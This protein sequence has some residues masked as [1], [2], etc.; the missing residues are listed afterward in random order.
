MDFSDFD[1]PDFDPSFFNTLDT[2]VDAAS[3]LPTQGSV[4]SE[5]TLQASARSNVPLHLNKVDGSNKSSNP[6][7]TRREA[8][9][10]ALSVNAP[11]PPRTEIHTTTSTTAPRSRTT[12]ASIAAPRS[13]VGTR[14]T[15]N[16]GA[17]DSRFPQIM[18]SCHARATSS[19]YHTTILD[20]DDSSNEVSTI[21][22]ADVGIR[23]KE[24]VFEG[25]PSRALTTSALPSSSTHISC[26]KSRHSSEATVV[27]ETANTPTYAQSR[28]IQRDPA[29]NSKNGSLVK[30]WD[31]TQY[32]ATG[33]RAQRK[34]AKEKARLAARRSNFFN[35]QDMGESESDDS[36]DD[37]NESTLFPEPVTGTFLLCRSSSTWTHQSH[38]C[39]SRGQS[40]F[41]VAIAM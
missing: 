18:P 17:E 19:S 37:M 41:K 27:T 40:T 1:E 36:E 34:R 14:H 23:H 39:S 20:D 24:T 8:L 26:S 9:L 28:L 29:R 31:R 4:A 15:I 30:S 25:N 13:S 38:Q 33:P 2:L 16:G 21:K 35:E 5:K 7:L 3:S 32:A 11:L 22:N 10:A 6:K 12:D